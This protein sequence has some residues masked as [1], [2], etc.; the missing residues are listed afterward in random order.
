MTTSR[1]HQ[2][3]KSEWCRL[4]LM[5]DLTNIKFPKASV[6]HIPP[7]YVPSPNAF[8]WACV[9][10]PIWASLVSSSK[11]RTLNALG[12][13]TFRKLLMIDSL[14]SYKLRISF[15]LHSGSVASGE[16][17]TGIDSESVSQK[18]PVMWTKSALIL[19][20]AASV[21]KGE[22]CT[23]WE[24]CRKNG[25]RTVRSVFNSSTLSRTFHKS[26]FIMKASFWLLTP[27]WKYP[28]MCLSSALTMTE[29]QR[30]NRPL[31]HAKGPL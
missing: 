16:N 23:V 22:K 18:D 7:F 13:N 5:P 21:C 31:C 4:P 28:P 8:P 25:T 1:R 11:K 27:S 26:L 3:P 12:C 14:S 15:Y 20:L 29:S 30:C 19:N 24:K 10:N 6:T 17:F 9:A 2:S